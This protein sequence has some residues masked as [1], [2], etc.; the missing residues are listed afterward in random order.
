MNKVINI[1]K[2]HIFLIFKYSEVVYSNNGFYFVNQKVQDYFQERKVTAFIELINHLLS[3]ELLK[4]A[5]Q[6]I[7]SY[8]RDRCIE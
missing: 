3:T 4:W 2:N 1:Y 8:L 5:V 6:S 7:M